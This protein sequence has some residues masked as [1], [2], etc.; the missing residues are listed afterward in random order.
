MVSAGEAGGVL[1]IV[2]VR[3]SE[4][5]ERERKLKTAVSSALFYPAILMIMSSIAL[6]I[7][8]LFVIP[9]FTIMFSEMNVTLP[10]PTRI[11]IG[12]TNFVKAHWWMVLV[13][14]ITITVLFRFY[15]KSENGKK[16]I[17]RI[18]IQTPLLGHMFR[19]F[20]LARFSRTL[21]TLL[22]NGVLMLTALKIVKET[23]G[24][25]VYRDAI[26]TC[27]HELEHGSTLALP[28]GKSGVFPSL[29]THMIS[30][31][32]ESGSPEEMLIKLAEYYDTEVKK[33]LDR[34]TSVLGPIVILIMGLIIGSMAVSIILP[35]L[36]ASTM[37]G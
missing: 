29:L 7:L 31:G 2:L 33:Y 13:A 8:T 32:E 5:A 14:L 6:L 24:N 22:E 34:I 36:E 23:I 26:E 35:I 27:A 1:G 12:F 10:L 37:L 28:M 3:L 16:E 18:K 21:S 4:F 9:K 15:A 11:L 19:A 30:I 25:R 17:D 20:A